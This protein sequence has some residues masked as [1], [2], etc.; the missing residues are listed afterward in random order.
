MRKP[1]R[2]VLA[3]ASLTLAMVGCR[4]DQSTEPQQIEEPGSIE[5]SF[6]ITGRAL[7]VGG[8]TV[9]VDDRLSQALNAGGRVRFVDL[10]AGD[11]DVRLDGLAANC[12]VG[13]A[14][15][16]TVTVA[17][18]QAAAARFDAACTQSGSSMHACPNCTFD[19]VLYTRRTGTPVTELI[20]FEANTDG[21]YVLETNDMDTRGAE[22][23]IWL[24]GERM[25]VGRG[26]Q[27]RDVV[28]DSE[29][30]LTVR[31]TGK[32]GSK[33]LVKIFQEVATVEV[34]PAT[35][36]HRYN[37][38]QQ[39]TAVARDRN[40]V[41]IPRQTFTWGSGDTDIATVGAS[42]G[43]ARTVGPQHDTVRWSY[44]TISQ[45]V[46]DAQIIAHAD[47]SP[48]KQGTAT[49]TVVAGFVYVTYQA[50]LP[51]ASPNRDDR[52]NPVPFQYDEVR[53]SQ[54]AVTCA[55]EAS[56]LAW[57]EWS[58]PGERLFKQCFPAWEQSNLHRIWV[59]PTRL[60][61]GF[62]VY[63]FV[64]NVGLY[65][66]YC[67]GGHP[68]GDWYQ[69]YANQGN[70]QPKDAID[71]ICMEHDRQEAHHELTPGEDDAQAACIVR[72]GIEAE[73][74]YEEGVLVQ[75]GSA[76]WNAFWSQWP[77]MA[78]ARENWLVETSA[79]CFGPIYKAFREDRGI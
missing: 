72:W 64:P 54:M 13:G 69:S 39:F 75:P 51:L 29:N 60:T 25:K 76:R 28:L 7:D 5:V 67:G 45:G 33:L 16:R 77:D 58:L 4:D 70:Y 65:G 42:T 50:P 79:I 3:A 44:K 37:A 14:N 30:T 19:P 27:R 41:D 9:W 35:A 71:A 55:S 20:E 12:A 53:L 59:P 66:R 23:R 52:P 26:V 32:P 49:W 43:L 11:H 2:V 36:R 40:G 15:P 74:L 17:G 18:G 46:G 57:R 21:A 38:T 61:D 68:D 22:S 34:T 62:Y 78:E 8:V 1:T 6:E 63:D 73:R 10:E 48:D 24:N 31:L 47:G 56:N